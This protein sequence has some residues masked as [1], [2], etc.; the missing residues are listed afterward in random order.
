MIAERRVVS[1]D[2]PDD[3]FHPLRDRHP[4][5]IG[6]RPDVTIASAEAHG[7]GELLDERIH[8]RPQSRNP[9]GIVA[10]LGV[11]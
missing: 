2:L 8:L 11:A 3:L 6:I 4:G 9:S 7:A 5:P 10:A 1:A